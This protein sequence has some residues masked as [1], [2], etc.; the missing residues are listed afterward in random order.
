MSDALEPEVYDRLWQ[1]LI[2]EQPEPAKEYFRYHRQRFYELFSTLQTYLPDVTAPRVLEVGCSGFSRLYKQLFP[3]LALTIVDRPV[4]LNG[5]GAEFCLDVCHAE[6]S[7]HIDLNVD[8][9]SP[10][11][12]TP[13]LGEFDYVICTEVIEHLIVNPVEFLG[14]LLS[15][16]KP[17]GY[18]YL[19]TPNLF[20]HHHLLQI[21]RRENPQA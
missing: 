7:C 14:S 18:L 8:V 3:R 13:P 21:A 20:S 17:P 5:A 6:R 1:Q 12:G 10:A 19:T 16:L 15:L 4:E 9:L 11:W 2:A